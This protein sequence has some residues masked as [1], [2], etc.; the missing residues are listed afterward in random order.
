MQRADERSM[1][2][3]W[4]V[5]FFLRLRQALQ[6]LFRPKTVRGIATE[7]LQACLTVDRLGPLMTEEK[8]QEVKSNL[9]RVLSQYVHIS[10]PDGVKMELQAVR[11]C[12]SAAC[13]Q[14]A[15]AHAASARS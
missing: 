6:E 4:L 9:V 7:R 8:M 14:S 3:N 15:S 10:D 1:Q 2:T 13:A 11:S 12:D 5:S